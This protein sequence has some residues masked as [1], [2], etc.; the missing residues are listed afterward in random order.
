[1]AQTPS[2]HPFSPLERHYGLCSGRTKSQ[3]YPSSLHLERLILCPSRG[4]QM[5]ATK[6][7]PADGLVQCLGDPLVE[8]S[9]PRVELQSSL[10]VLPPC[11]PST[12]IFTAVPLPRSFPGVIKSQLR[13]L[14][15]S[16]L[17]QPKPANPFLKLLPVHGLFCFNLQ[18]ISCTQCCWD[19]ECVEMPWPESL[20]QRSQ[21]RPLA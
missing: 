12:A 9:K 8:S 3:S 4:H 11:T 7:I 16:A 21:R 2:Y 20:H 17:G 14:P 10:C 19:R 6:A 18:N 13:P 1:M 15:A 5:G